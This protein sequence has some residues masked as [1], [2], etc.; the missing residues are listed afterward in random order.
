MF[1]LRKRHILKRILT[2]LQDTYVWNETM[3][4]WQPMREAMGTQASKF[5]GYL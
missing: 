2:H 4:G 1:V 5:G 3:D